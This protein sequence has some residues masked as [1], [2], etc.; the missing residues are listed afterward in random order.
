MKYYSTR[1]K[2]LRMDAAQAIKMG[3]SRD[4]GLLT[5]CEIPQVD[6][7]FLRTL[8]PASY[9]ERA[10]RVMTLYLTDYTEAEL[11][12]FA[13]NAYGADKYDTPAVAPVRTVDET[14]HCLELWH[15]PTSA[16][17]DMALQMLPHLLSAALKKTGETRTACILVATSGDTG[18]AALEGFR[19]VP[20]TKILVFYPR[21]GV[22]EI[23]KLQMVTQEGKNVGVCSVVG[24]FDDAQTGVKRIFSDEEIRK[25]LND[26]GYFLSSANSINWGRVLP[27]II[28]Y[29][30]VWC[31]LRR[32][33]KIGDDEKLTVC[34]PTGNF[35]NILSACYA[36]LMG[37]PIGKLVCASNCND[38]LTEFL[39]TGVYNRNRPF[40]T[41][42]SPSMDILIS[43]NLERLLFLLSGGNDAEVRSY[44]DS[45]AATGMY[46]VSDDTMTK[47]KELF[48]AGSCDEADTS[49]AINEYYTK[50]DYL[51]DPHSAV[52]ASVLKEYRAKTGDSATAVFA[53][54][55]SPYKFCGSVLRSIGV[56]PN[57]DGVGL[58][59][60]LQSVSGVKAPERLASLGTKEK[61]FDR[62]AE[63]QDM[64]KV[65]LDILR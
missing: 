29:V 6:G 56:E 35:G 3:L 38:V 18:K 37:V 10:A 15:G 7:E 20:H 62:V 21:D 58:I 55:A 32:A 54:T 61:R 53:S 8:I 44:M 41:T 5:P 22:S 13:G 4:G 31:D 65:V 24:N 30:S 57:G 11:R 28:Y 46:K 63:K 40:H 23:Q 50:Y 49:A 45:L 59:G 51:I 9:Q 60:Q 1:D 48:W 33:G 47:I 42:M 12:E 26:R 16:F 27:Q 43:S 17:K 14:T 39:R 34:V 25:T 19:D 2:S 52:A 36:K 64:D